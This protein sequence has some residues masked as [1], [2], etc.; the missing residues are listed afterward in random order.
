MPAQVWY[1]AVVAICTVALIAWAA[2]Q[3][4]LY[5]GLSATGD[6]DAGFEMGSLLGR[7]GARLVFESER[8]G[9][10]VEE[11]IKRQHPNGGPR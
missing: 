10:T 5:K 9:V 2:Y 8:E 7:Y 3:W 11:L 1:I 4:G 6:W